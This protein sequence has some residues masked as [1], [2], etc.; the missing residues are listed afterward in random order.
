M[1]KTIPILCLAIATIA[2]LFSCKEDKSQTEDIQQTVVDSLEMA[3]HEVDSLLNSGKLAHLDVYEIGKIKSISMSVQK[4]QVAE[5]A[6][7]WINLS[8][9]C[10]GQ[11]YYS[12]EDAHLLYDECPY[13]IKAIDS[14]RENTNRE[15][16]HEEHYGYITKDNIRISSYASKGKP[17]K[18]YFSVDY[19][20]QNSSITLTDK[21]IDDL[22]EL[23]KRGQDKIKELENQ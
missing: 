15:V 22:I 18:I 3:L 20:K 5:H 6:T 16:D 17:W 9:D 21:D 19:H 13:L 4:I 7:I 1:K 23:I 11:Y 10:G 2:L 14:I 12:R 8:K